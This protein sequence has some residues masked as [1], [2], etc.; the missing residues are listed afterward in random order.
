MSS[1]ND[2]DILMFFAI[3]VLN[4][5][6]LEELGLQIIQND[7]KDYLIVYNG[8]SYNMLDNGR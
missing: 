6:L 2:L 5:E 3:N 8:I 1:H 7:E 4:R